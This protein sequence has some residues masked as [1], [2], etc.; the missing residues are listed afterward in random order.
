MIPSTAADLQQNVAATAQSSDM[1]R[2]ERLWR[3]F[4]RA[5]QKPE[6]TTYRGVDQKQQSTASGFY[7]SLHSKTNN[8]KATHQHTYSLNIG[9]FLSFELLPINMLLAIT[10]GQ[11]KIQHWC[12][13]QQSESSF[14]SSFG[15]HHLE[16]VF[17]PPSVKQSVSKRCFF[18]L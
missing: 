10:G 14:S 7:W 18:F 12:S 9:T 5:V 6:R 3:Y 13:I 15:L 16:Y 11:R 8:Y 2:T 4:T 17:P 1:N